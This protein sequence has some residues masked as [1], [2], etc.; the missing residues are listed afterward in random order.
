MSTGPFSDLLVDHPELGLLYLSEEHGAWSAE[1]SGLEPGDELQVFPGH[2][3]AAANLHDT[4]YAV[5]NGIVEE[6]WAVT[7]RGRS[8]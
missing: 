6:V 5:R 1:A 7:A 8:Q 4:V 2:C 3:C